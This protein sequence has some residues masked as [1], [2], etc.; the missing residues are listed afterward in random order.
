M[1]EKHSDMMN[2]EIDPMDLGMKRQDEFWYELI[3]FTGDENSNAEFLLAAWDEQINVYHAWREYAATCD[4][5][6]TSNIVRG[7]DSMQ[8]RLKHEFDL[9]LADAPMMTEE[10]AREQYMKLEATIHGYH[11]SQYVIPKGYNDLRY[12]YQCQSA[13]HDMGPLVVEGPG[14]DVIE[15][16]AVIEGTWKV[17]HMMTTDTYETKIEC[18]IERQKAAGRRFDH[19]PWVWLAILTEEVGEVAATLNK[20]KPPEDMRKEL[21]QCAAVI[22][23]WLVEGN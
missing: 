18:E 10:K 17:A 9:V 4:N 8:Y 15:I 16:L 5:V 1:M 13:S 12:M 2:A 23:A 7:D 3:Y 11:L 6:K 21:I 19:D 20:N 22:K 14:D